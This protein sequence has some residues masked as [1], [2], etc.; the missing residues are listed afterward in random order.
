MKSVISCEIAK[1]TLTDLVHSFEGPSD[2]KENKIKDLKLE[3]NTFRVKPFGSGSGWQ[4]FQENSDDEVDERTSE[5]YLRDLDI[6]FHERALLAGSK[7]S[8]GFQPKFTPKLIQ[9]TQQVLIAL[10]NDKLAVGKNHAR[11]GEWIDITMTKVNILLSMDEDVDWQN[12]LKYIDIDLKFVEEQR[13][14][15]DSKLPN[16]NTGR[17][18]V[19]ESQAVNE[20]LGLTEAPTDLE[21]SKEL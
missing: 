18:L 19:P 4:D 2:T 17:L 14:N 6:E 1:D 16:F 10:A 9:S 12:Y 11:N 20:T 21:S 8:S 3:Y 5:E 15:P 13:H 7:R